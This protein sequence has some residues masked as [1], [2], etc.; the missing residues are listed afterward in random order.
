MESVLERI[1]SIRKQKGYSHEYLA[2]ELDISQVAYSK[3]EKNET[4]LTVERLFKLAEI[5]ET[6][7]ADLLDIKANNIYHQNNSDQAI[8]HQEVQNLYQ[9]NKDKTDKIIELYEARLQDKDRLI[10]QLSNKIKF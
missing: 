4:K 6:P 10:A 3:L 1:K 7:I 9:E 5:L 8:G 2:Q